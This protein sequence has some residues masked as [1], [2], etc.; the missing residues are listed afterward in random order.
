M[1][2]ASM[3]SCRQDTRTPNQGLVTIA[4]SGESG[5]AYSNETFTADVRSL[6]LLGKFII[7]DSAGIWARDG[8]DMYVIAGNNRVPTLADAVYGYMPDNGMSD[9]QQQQQQPK[10]GDHALQF[11]RLQNV[12]D[13]VAV[14]ITNGIRSIGPFEDTQNAFMVH[15]TVYETQTFVHVRWSWLTFL[16]AQVVLAFGFFAWTVAATRRLGARVHKSSVLATLFALY[17]DGPDSQGHGARGQGGRDI[18]EMAKSSRAQV[19]EKVLLLS[20]MPVVKKVDV[21]AQNEAKVE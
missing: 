11:C 4:G 19:T 3:T 6:T 17:S 20:T 7:Q 12:A 1:Y 9:R 21:E 13:N 16:A 10:A 2:S 15:G 8:D 14:S 5:V 18:E